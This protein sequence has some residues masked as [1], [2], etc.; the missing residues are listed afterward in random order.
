MQLFGFIAIFPFKVDL[1]LRHRR[2]NSS[3]LIIAVCR[4]SLKIMCVR[5]QVCLMQCVHGFT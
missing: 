5:L 3:F 4:T 1:I 2:G